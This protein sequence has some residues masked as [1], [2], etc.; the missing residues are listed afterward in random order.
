LLAA[1]GCQTHLSLGDNTLRTGGTLTDLNYQ[2]VHNNVAM[3][4]ANPSAMPS[5]AVIN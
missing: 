5:V 4:V 3:F 2:Q 1:G